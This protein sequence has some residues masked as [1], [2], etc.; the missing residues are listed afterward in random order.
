MAHRRKKP[1][2]TIVSEFVGA[3][4]TDQNARPEVTGLGSR[5]ATLWIFLFL[6]A[7][8]VV[9]IGGGIYMYDQEINAW[10]GDNFDRELPWLAEEEDGEEADTG[11]TGGADTTTGDAVDET[12]TGEPTTGEPESLEP[13]FAFGELE[14]SGRLAKSGVEEKLDQVKPELEKCYD[15]TPSAKSLTGTLPVKISIK[16][17]GSMSK[18]TAKDGKLYDKA[19]EACFRKVVRKVKFPK[20]RGAGTATAT[21][22][23]TL[24]GDAPAE[25][26]KSP[27]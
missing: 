21:L 26:A 24:H 1:A 13:S 2:G 27:K 4:R 14:V 22:P 23:I 6:I 3:S 17:N 9:I 15:D 11:T 10:L 7:G 25:P 12:T 20:P 18:L 8:T 16:W 19:L 5:Y